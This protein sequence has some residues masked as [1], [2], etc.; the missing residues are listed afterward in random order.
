MAFFK[1]A[2]EK[3]RLKLTSEWFTAAKKGE[4][5]TMRIILEQD[6]GFLN[7]RDAEGKTALMLAAIALK[8]EAAIWLKNQGASVNEQDDRGYTI[9]HH[10]VALSSTGEFS[11]Y[12][13]NYN[14]L[15]FYLTHG[16]IPD[17]RD[18]D[19]NTPLHLAALQKK[20]SQ[21]ISALFNCPIDQS[22]KNEAGFT[23][24][25]LAAKHHPHNAS[26][27]LEQARR[28]ETGRKASPAIIQPAPA[29]V[30]ASK[31]EPEPEVV[32]DWVKTDQNE[33][34]RVQEKNAIGYRLTE[35][36]NFSRQTYICLSRNIGTDVETQLHR[37]FS[38]FASR[39]ILEE[40]AEAYHKITGIT[41]D[42]GTMQ[43]PKPKLQGV[44]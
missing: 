2:E 31:P 6:S 26:T 9:F 35:I 23:A 1:S 3:Q 12:Q 15:K 13:Y 14:E 8:R 11:K 34:A 18:T 33:I 41:P 21:L 24:A 16:A 42:I 39:N 5:G 25:E 7:L 28:F 43:L 29:P 44:K 40:A 10:L 37:D 32:S 30:A 4:T 19:G 22:I 38:D 27:F 17:I 20:S 36:F